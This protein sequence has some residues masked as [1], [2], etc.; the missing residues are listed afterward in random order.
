MFQ[1]LAPQHAEAP[2]EFVPLGYYH[3]LRTWIDDARYISPML[4][5]LEIHRIDH[6]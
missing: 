6:K 1:P 2:G 4:W 5:E 3:W